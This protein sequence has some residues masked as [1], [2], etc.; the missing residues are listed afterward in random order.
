MGGR[1]CTRV[2]ALLSGAPGAYELPL[3]VGDDEEQ[4]GPGRSDGR[5]A[6]GGRPAEF[7]PPSLPSSFFLLLYKQETFANF[8]RCL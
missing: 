4:G 7:V 6:P 5:R 3:V 1:Q 8:S 2:R